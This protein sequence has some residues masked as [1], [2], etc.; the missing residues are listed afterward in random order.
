MLPF[1]CKRCGGDLYIEDDVSEKAIA[2][3]QCGAR[4]TLR[5]VKRYQNLPA[6][7]AE[8]SEERTKYNAAL[9]DRNAE[10]YRLYMNGKTM[11]ELCRQFQRKDS[12]IKQIIAGE[13]LKEG[14]HGHKN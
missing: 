4:F 10:V 11:R 9:A 1:K 2:C 14:I 6:A 5:K 8:E 3:L 13:K 12:T 7:P